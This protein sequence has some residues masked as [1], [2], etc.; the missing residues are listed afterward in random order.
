[1]L[2]QATRPEAVVYDPNDAIS[3]GS[4]IYATSTATAAPTR[5]SRTSCAATWPRSPTPP[6]SSPPTRQPASPRRCSSSARSTQFS[7][8]DWPEVARAALAA[9]VDGYA[10]GRG[11]TPAST[12]SAGRPPTTRSP[13]SVRS[14]PPGP[15]QQW[16][17][18]GPQRHGGT[19]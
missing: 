16:L 19:R 15:G 10:A 7:T 12:R 14:P 9:Y 11:P 4:Q 8:L 1:M 5:P 18:A 13:R 17:D 6:P 3:A 2:L